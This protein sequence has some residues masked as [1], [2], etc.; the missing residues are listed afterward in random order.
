M[1]SKKGWSNRL[2]RKERKK[3]K[4]SSDQK[5]PKGES[6][7]IICYECRKSGHMR[8]DC[9]RLNKKKRWTSKKDKKK[10]LVTWE[11]L[12]KSSNDSSNEET[13]NICLM[14]DDSK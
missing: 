6:S 12:D 2:F 8:S 1:M 5:D 14:T 4:A 11:D 9:P 13:A 10:S 3:D 7:E